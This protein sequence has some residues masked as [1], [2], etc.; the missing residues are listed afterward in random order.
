MH[1]C[2]KHLYNKKF[3]SYYLDDLL[4]HTTPQQDH[5]ESLRQVFQA[6]RENNLH[7]DI[8]KCEFG[9]KRITYLGHT[10]G[11]DGIGP[12]Q[13]K[14]DTIQK[15]PVPET[16]ENVHHFLGLLSWF[17]KFIPHFSQQSDLLQQIISSQEFVWTEAHTKQ[18]E[19]LKSLIL[20]H[21]TLP[22]F[23]TG[24]DTAVWVYSSE[25]AVGGGFSVEACFLSFQD[26]T[27]CSI[28]VGHT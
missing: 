26:I 28:E 10:A 8:S 22:C 6:L 2:L 9:A 24:A 19:A 3:L 5:V 15:W 7:A 16:V 27:S 25:F 1:K 14:L 11:K 13:S 20:N 4:T 12:E 17:R 18:F 23:Q 21:V